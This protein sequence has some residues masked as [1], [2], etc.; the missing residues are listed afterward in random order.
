M[1]VSN[2]D[3]VFVSG[4]V[5]LISNIFGMIS[6]TLRLKG[7]VD[8]NNDLKISKKSKTSK[9]VQAKR[10]ENFELNI[11]NFIHIKRERTYA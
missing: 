5:S 11:G 4:L 10:R 3:F 2:V 7:Q 8:K 1:I 9:K 6:E